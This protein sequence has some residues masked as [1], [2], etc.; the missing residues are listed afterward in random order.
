MSETLPQAGV[1]VRC[2]CGIL[3]PAQ[4]AHAGFV[5]CEWCATGR[6]SPGGWTSRPV[7][8]PWCSQRQVAAAALRWARTHGGWQSSGN[9]FWRQP[10]TGATVTVLRDLVDTDGSPLVELVIRP[11]EAGLPVFLPVSSARQ[12]VDLLVV[13]GLLP[14]SLAGGYADGYGAGWRAHA[15]RPAAAASSRRRAE[16]A[17]LVGHARAALWLPGQEPAQRLA[18]LR[19]LF[20]TSGHGDPLERAAAAHR[21]VGLSVG[22][23]P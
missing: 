1:E 5:D 9:S 16:L 20:G 6:P 13:Y 8:P 23:R 4:E 3:L 15:T 18:E 21:E 7:T 11:A 19:R 14:S 2:G 17:R 10:S 22:G 12:A